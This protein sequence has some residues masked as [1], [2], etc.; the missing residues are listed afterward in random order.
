M[1]EHVLFLNQKGVNL[2]TTIR[3]T[4]IVAWC[5]IFIIRFLKNISASSGITEG[6]RK[7]AFF[8]AQMFQKQANSSKFLERLFSKSNKII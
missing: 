2:I 7:K 6:F 8:Y 3:S 1:R 4:Y 5:N